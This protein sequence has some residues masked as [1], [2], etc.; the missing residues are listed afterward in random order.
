MSIG[1]SVDTAEI[2]FRLLRSEI[3]GIQID[4]E[5][6]K[7]LTSESVEAVYSLAAG[8]DLAHIVG[9]ALSNLGVL[10]NSEVSQ[11]FKEASMQAVRRYIHLS[12][13][14]GE[15]CQTLESAHIPFIP[16]KGAVIRDY[17][18]EPWMRTSCDIDVLVKKE[19][20]QQAAD[21]LVETLGYIAKGV[22]DHDMALY[23]PAGVRLELHY[24]TIQPR[25]EINNCRDVLSGIWNDAVA[26]DEKTYRHDMSDAMCYFYHMAHM[27]K[28]IRGGGCGIRPILDI[29]LMNHNIT[30]DSQARQ[31]LL[32][33]G[34]LLKFAQA[35]E[36]VAE[37][38]F[39]GA[40]PDLHTQQVIDY[41]LRAGTYGNY[42][43]KA[44]YGQAK[45]GG[46]L[47]Y[48]MSTRVFLPYHYIKM[49]YPV[50]EKYK[51]LVPLFQIVRW[52]D[53]LRKGQ[54]KRGIWELRM[55]MQVSE[56]NRDET[57][58]LQEYLGI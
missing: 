29:W 21:A 47:G 51:W 6:E 1:Y 53:L 36:R 20:L 56:E 23:S 41:I 44:I 16:L 46:R 17:Y 33:E 31:A 27:T 7:R 26:K 38:W 2:M 11:K 55:N 49:S 57:A 9:Q 24:D 34:G 28:H 8:H 5:I 4:P 54:L 35:M 30:F 50:L 14:Y 13:A 3:C 22:G 32:Q 52:F 43:N 37:V 40:Q 39:S 48:L 12:H 15:I 45:K 25:W 18:P 19:N 42:E 58:Q 10:D